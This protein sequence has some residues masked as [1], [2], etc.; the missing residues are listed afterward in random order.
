M[1]SSIKKS[2]I[3][4]QVKSRDGDVNNFSSLIDD[5]LQYPEMSVDNYR[6]QVKIL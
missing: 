3:K 1:I 5:I 2:Q 6:E 4:E